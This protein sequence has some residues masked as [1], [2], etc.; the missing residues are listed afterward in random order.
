M[1]TLFLFFALLLGLAGFAQSPSMILRFGNATTAF[2]R[3]IPVGVVLVDVNTGKLYLSLV[4]LDNTKSIATCSSSEIR[5]I[6]YVP[7]AA[8]QAL[9]GTDVAWDVTNGTNATLT[10]TGNT[11][12]TLSHLV[13]GSS[14]NLTVTN[15]GTLYSLTLTGY[16]NVISPAIFLSANSV[17]T[18]G[19]GKTDLFSWYFDGNTLFW[20][21]TLDYK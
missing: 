4:K 2:G 21:G 13:A 5:E 9:S 6:R 1:K 3:N 18:S 19:S 14:G 12:I 11:T 16:T 10:L 15:A 7:N 8:L 20:N 17:A